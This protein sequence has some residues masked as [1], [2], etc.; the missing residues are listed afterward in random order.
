MTSLH[1]EGSAVAAV[2]R[3]LHPQL[4]QLREL[5]AAEEIWPGVDFFREVIGELERA[6]TEVDLQRLFTLHLGVS[7]PLARAAGFPPAAL[8]QLDAILATAQAIAL[9][10]SVGTDR[11]Q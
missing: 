11:P 3:Q 4:V 6:E 9:T 8:A 2:R 5:L 10:F 1:D 7:G